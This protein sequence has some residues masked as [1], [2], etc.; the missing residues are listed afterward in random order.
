MGLIKHTPD[1]TLD[2]VTIRRITGLE[3][4]RHFQALDDLIWGGSD[5]R[6][7]VP[8]HVT[9]TI[10]KNG[11]LL[12]GAYAPNGPDATD[13]MVGAALG[14]LGTGLDPAQRAAGPRLKFCSHIVGVLPAWQGLHI[15]LRL[16]LAQRREVLAQGLTDWMTWTYDPLY[17]RNGVFNLHR[18]G[19]TCATYVRDMYGE[20]QDVLN[21]GVPSDRCEVDWRLTSPHVL[22]DLEPRRPT[23]SWDAAALEILPAATNA[24]G[25]AVPAD[26]APALDG[27]PLAVPIP[28][29]IAAIR[30]AD[31]A[32]SRAWRLYLRAALE[33]A[34]AAG[35]T[36]VDCVHLDAHGWSYILVREY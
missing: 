12:L 18:L 34:F 2:A 21:A 1:P 29:D 3:G 13:G 30:R 27:R 20:L 5:P 16:K 4:C 26:P 32:L 31:P 25:F 10:V 17:R 9:V 7:L 33:M 11:G 15:G 35:Y 28:D 22:H 14:W 19:A 6:D 24:A 8:N 23:P 36:M